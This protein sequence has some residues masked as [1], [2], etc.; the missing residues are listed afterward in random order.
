MWAGDDAM[1]TDSQV[2]KWPAAA[3]RTIKML[4]SEL[5]Y[6]DNLVSRLRQDVNDSKQDSTRE[7]NDGLEVAADVCDSMKNSLADK[8]A[9]KIRRLKV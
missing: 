5:E 3:R 8:C 2:S 4:V 1:C 7:Y 6:S 9:R